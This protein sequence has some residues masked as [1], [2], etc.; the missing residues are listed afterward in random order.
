VK[1]EK[2]EHMGKK[3]HE[4]MGKHGGQPGLGKKEVGFSGKLGKKHKSFGKEMSPA[5]K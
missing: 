2:K 3:H 4:G 1:E 5:G